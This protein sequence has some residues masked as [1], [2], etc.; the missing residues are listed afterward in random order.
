MDFLD[1]QKHM[2]NTVPFVC[3]LCVTSN[4]AGYRG[5][6]HNNISTNDAVINTEN[7]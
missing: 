4:I 7:V 2:G 5:Y 6:R 1:F 3:C